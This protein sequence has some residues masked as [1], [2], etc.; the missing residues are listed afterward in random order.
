[1]EDP[2]HEIFE[3]LFNKYGKITVKDLI[4]AYNNIITYKYDKAPYIYRCVNIFLNEM[5]VRRQCKEL[6]LVQQFFY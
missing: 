3:R 2:I 4:S 1:M 5:C 6:E